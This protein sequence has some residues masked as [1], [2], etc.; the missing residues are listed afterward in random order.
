MKQQRV[1]DILIE[2]YL[3]GELPESKRE[4]VENS[5]G[6]SERVRALEQS[7]T[8]ILEQYPADQFVSRIMNQYAAESQ[9]ELATIKE[10]PRRPRLRWLRYALPGAAAVLVGAVLL[11]QSVFGP[12]TAPGNNE[13]DEV[14]RLKGG[15][16]QLSVFRSVDEP[17]TRDDSAEELENGAIARAGDRL[18]LAYNA[19]SRQFGAIVSVDGRGAVFVHFPYTLSAEPRLVVGRT[20]RLRVGYQLDDAPRFEHFYFITNDEVF[21]VQGLVRDIR[22]QASSITERADS[23]KLDDGFEITSVTILKGE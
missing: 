23:L 8:E 19:G 14:V 18:Q 4:L 3:L 22:S 2:Q 20:E 21:S 12:G 11:L 13:F 5:P 1:P 6:F 9:R 10:A 16:A 15:D 17:D 7:N